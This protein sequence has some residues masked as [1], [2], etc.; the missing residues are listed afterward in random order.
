MRRAGLPPDHAEFG[1][2]LAPDY[3]GRHAYAVEIGRG[4]L[5]FAFRELRVGIVTGSTVSAN[6]RISRLAAW[7][8]AEMVTAHDGGEWMAARDWS[9]VEWH[10]TREQWQHRAA[11]VR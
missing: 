4:M 5:D 8:G 2:E 3:W 6:T 1:I 9:N 7:F 11:H 10:L